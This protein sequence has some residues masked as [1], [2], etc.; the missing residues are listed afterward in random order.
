MRSFTCSASILN[1]CS[2]PRP[3]DAEFRMPD[4]PR[5]RRESAVTPRGMGYTPPKHIGEASLGRLLAGT[6]RPVP[7][8]SPQRSLFMSGRTR[9]G[10]TVYYAGNLA[11][12]HR[13]CVAIVGTRKV[14]AAGEARTRR[15]ARELALEGIVVVSGLA[16]GVDTAAHSACIEAGG[17]TIAVIG[18][19]MDTATPASNQALQ[20]LIY[21]QHLLLSPFPIGSRVHKGNFPQRNQVMAAISD[22]TVVIEASDTSGT[23]HQ[24]KEA[25]GLGRWLF[26]ARSC[27]EDPSLRWPRSFLNATTAKVL[28][29]TADI[30]ER[31]S[32]GG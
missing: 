24:S 13:P 3:Q 7:E 4:E 19:P 14:S 9:A 17:S 30:V 27:A 28:N 20:E 12:L 29:S 23:L 11:L 8:D 25:V 10:M 18:T 16:M 31:I 26:I 2:I 22:A 1:T 21:R 15:L 6:N 5:S 32:L